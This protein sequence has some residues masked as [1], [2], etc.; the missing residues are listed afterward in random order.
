MQLVDCL[1]PFA[2]RSDQRKSAGYRAV[3][4]SG[5]SQVYVL[6]LCMHVICLFVCMYVR[7]PP[8]PLPCYTCVMIHHVS[9][10]NETCLTHE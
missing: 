10:M 9:R 1:L 2:C 5:R 3:G 8:P 7:I 4:T 6:Y